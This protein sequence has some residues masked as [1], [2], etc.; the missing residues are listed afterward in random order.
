ML[1]LKYDIESV[2]AERHDKRVIVFILKIVDE[3]TIRFFETTFK[4]YKLTYDGRT[5]TMEL[6]ISMNNMRG[7]TATGDLWEW[8]KV[9]KADVVRDFVLARIKGEV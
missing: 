4:G 1:D 9:N 7:A 2:K 3:A 5:F 8:L 6:P